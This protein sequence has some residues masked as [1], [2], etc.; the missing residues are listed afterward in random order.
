MMGASIRG[1]ALVSLGQDLARYRDGLAAAGHKVDLRD[2]Q[3]VLVVDDAIVVADS[4]E[5]DP[6]MNFNVTGALDTV[7]F[8][9]VLDVAKTVRSLAPVARIVAVGGTEITIEDILRAVRQRNGVVGV[10]TPG[11][12]VYGTEGIRLAHLGRE[13]D[14]EGQAP[15]LVAKAGLPVSLVGKMADVVWCPDAERIPAVATG[16]V[17]AA[18]DDVM[19]RQRGGLIAVNVQELDLAG[20][21][22]D[23]AEYMRVLQASDLGIGRVREELRRGDLLIVTAD[24]GDDPTTGPMHTREKV[25]VLANATGRSPSRPLGQ[26]ASLADSGA[27]IAEWLGVG[28]TSAGTSYARFLR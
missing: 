26:R 6:G 15:V 19:A 10:D 11:L 23:P 22:E 1:F 27:T 2:S 5:A 24:H 17:L 14:H 7:D 9:H 28:R 4:L 8:D 20:H 25:P 16:D 3:P 21:R 12:G 13:F 18:L